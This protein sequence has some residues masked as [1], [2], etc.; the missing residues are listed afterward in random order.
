MVIVRYGHIFHYIKGHLLRRNVIECKTF[1]LEDLF[2][3]SSTICIV[4]VTIKH[5]FCNVTPIQFVGH[6]A[7]KLT[8]SPVVE[9]LF[10]FVNDRIGV[11]MANVSNF[12]K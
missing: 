2:I 8:Q 10:V 11:T 4:L 12:S 3:I 9:S 6:A 7:Y 5:V 1:D